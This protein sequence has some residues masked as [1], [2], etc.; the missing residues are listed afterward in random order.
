MTG[1]TL[2]RLPFAPPHP[3]PY[4]SLNFADRPRNRP[5]QHP[6]LRRLAHTLKLP[7][8]ILR[9]GQI[10]LL[11]LFVSGCAAS[12]MPFAKL[13]PPNDK[14]VIYIYRP[15]FIAGSANVW[16]LSANGSPI[17]DVSNGGY[18]A[19]VTDPGN[20]TFSAK[21]RPG[22]LLITSILIREEELITVYA[23]AGS[24]YYIR[25]NLGPSMEMIPN[26]EG[27]REIAG[28]HRFDLA[29]TNAKH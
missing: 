19:Y 4:V 17:A 26:E 2:A 13:Q 24:S 29:D 12:G 20:V 3:Q 25:F 10:L 21:L 28:L 18:I 27:E 15:S 23:E 16:N 14:A 5:L 7:P 9:H 6:G 8:S 1:P 22:L 11:G